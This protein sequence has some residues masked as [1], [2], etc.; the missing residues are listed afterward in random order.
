MSR[1]LTS[2]IG[3]VAV[4][5]VSELSEIGPTDTIPGA[6]RRHFRRR[7][8]SP[9]W[10]RAMRRGYVC[11]G[12]AEHRAAAN[13]AYSAS[14]MDGGDDHEDADNAA[15]M[16]Y[17]SERRAALRG[18][19]GIEDPEG[20]IVLP[21]TDLAISCWFGGGIYRFPPSATGAHWHYV[22]EALSQ[23]ED[24]VTALEEGDP[25]YGFE[26]V[27]STQTNAR[28]APNALV[29]LARYHYAS[30]RSFFPYEAIRASMLSDSGSQ[31]T[32]L[33]SVAPRHYE[34][35][36][37]LPNKACTLVHMVAVADDEIAPALES[38]DPEKG[39]K[40]LYAVLCDHG[41]GACS[42]PERPSLASLPSFLDEWRTH[43]AALG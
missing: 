39:M 28:W 22:T 19:F 27:I 36:I 9:Q 41:I 43:V 17:C 23:P 37:Q 40:A 26:L 16:R 18:I 33:M 20:Q 8:R 24:P 15:F 11:L 21:P 30:G 42:I 5:G 31:L 32:F 29:A 6:T 35:V 13:L 2:V 14:D 38:A 10:S 34:P 3:L 1:Q 25:T 4:A 12:R 7:R